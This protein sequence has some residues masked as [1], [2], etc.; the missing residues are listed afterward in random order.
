DG[1]DLMPSLKSAKKRDSRPIFGMTGDKL[2]T[3]RQGQWKLHVRSPGPDLFSWMT[4][5]QKAAYQDPRGPDGVTIV[6]Q[7]EQ[8]QVNQHPGLETDGR[9]PAMMLFDLETDRGESNNVA[10]Q[11]PEVVKRLKTIFDQTVKEFP[12]FPSAP[13]DYLFAEPKKGER[14]T[15]MRLI[16]GELRYDRV[17]KP[18]RHLL[19]RP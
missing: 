11:K 14:R 15:L 5:E 3:I 18:Q 6:A 10:A 9:P 17:P 12:K 19:K 7:F 13:V 4:P 8:A 16:G 1:R 2:A